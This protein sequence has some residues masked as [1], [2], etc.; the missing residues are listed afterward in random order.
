MR[1]KYLPIDFRMFDSDDWFRWAVAELWP[2]IANTNL[3]VVRLPCDF[4]GCGKNRRRAIALNLDIGRWTNFCC[5]S[6]GNALTLWAK[7]KGLPLYFAAVDMCRIRKLPVPYFT[8]FVSG[9]DYD[10]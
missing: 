10:D 2:D 7:A 1:A 3:S 8:D 6:A 5:S 4:P 9:G